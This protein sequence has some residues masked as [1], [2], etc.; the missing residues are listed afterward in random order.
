MSR[1]IT[2]EDPLRFGDAS[3]TFLR[4][5]NTSIRETRIELHQTDT[6]NGGDQRTAVIKKVLRGPR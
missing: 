1:D 2:A 3:Q 4:G 5:T 6:E